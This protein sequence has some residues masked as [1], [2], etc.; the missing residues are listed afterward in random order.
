MSSISQQPPTS[1]RVTVTPE[2]VLLD[3]LSTQ[4]ELAS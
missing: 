2:I 4:T 1:A 3:V